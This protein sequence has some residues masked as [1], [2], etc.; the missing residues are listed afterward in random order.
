MYLSTV[1]SLFS[2]LTELFRVFC[3]LVHRKKQKRAARSGVFQLVRESRTK[4]FFLAL[5]VLV[6]LFTFAHTLDVHSS[7]VWQTE[8][9]ETQ[10]DYL[11][12]SC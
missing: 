9:M 3:L 8:T 12:S 6:T 2:D 4:D 11:E 7:I 5:V 1:V 10:K